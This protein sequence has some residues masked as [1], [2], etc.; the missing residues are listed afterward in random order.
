MIDLDNKQILDNNVLPLTNLSFDHPLSNLELS[1]FISLLSEAPNISQVY[2]KDD[3]DLNT[4]EKIKY[5]LEAMPTVN[6]EIIEKYILKELT[7]DEKNNI[8]TM[9]FINIDTWNIAYSKNDNCSLVTSL[10]KYRKIQEYL[11]EIIINIDN[12]NLSP[13]EK[14]C[15][16]YD[17]VKL[18]DYCDDDKYQRL[19]EIVID[20]KANSYGY[21]LVFKE[22]LDNIGISCL[23]EQNNI[24]DEDEYVCLAMI[25]DHKYELNG[26]YLFDPSSDTIA[27]EKYRNT[28]ARRLNYNFFGINVDKIGNMMSNVEY[29][30]IMKVFHAD[31]YNEF[32]QRL[33]I[34]ERKNGSDA[35]AKLTVTFNQSIDNIYNT[36]KNTDSI[37]ENTLLEIIDNNLNIEPVNILNNDSLMTMMSDNYQA[38]EKELFVSKSERL[39]RKIN[40]NKNIN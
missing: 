11:Q 15:Y 38:R 20:G 35:V 10:Y 30:G 21:N 37:N 26:I 24:N 5:L 7:T 9:N 14:V 27:K 19:P 4:I 22:L 25:N 17:R 31:T 2:F 12:K 29:L 32:K 6:D 36:I 23:I 18:L 28:W 34:F 1:S 13:L 3:C 39:I 16:L 40:D 8:M 33:K